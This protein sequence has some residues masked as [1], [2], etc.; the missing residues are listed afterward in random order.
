MDSFGG[1]AMVVMVQ[2][3]DGGVEEYLHTKVLLCMSNALCAVGEFETDIAQRLAEAVTAFI[4]A[5]DR[6]R[7]A[8][9]E[10]LS[11][12]KLVLAETGRAEAAAELQE[13]HRRRSLSRTRT[14]VVEAELLEIRDADMMSAAT[15]G[16][17][18]WSK[19]RVA[20]QVM[21]MFGLERQAARAVAGRVEERV[22]AMGISRAWSGLVRQLILSEAAATMRAEA[23]LASPVRE[24]ES[25]MLEADEVGV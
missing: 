1:P 5:M 20:S 12:V 15:T 3:A 25:P 16:M 14:E 21:E 10:I 9:G 24:V 7:I 2:K 19:G 4:Y 23:N 8:S 13:H 22:L 11:M 6:G 18:Q 17:R